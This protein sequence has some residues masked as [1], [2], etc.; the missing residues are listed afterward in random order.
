MH[1]PMFLYNAK[2]GNQSMVYKLSIIALRSKVFDGSF[3]ISPAPSLLQKQYPPARP[4][5]PYNKLR[6]F[7]VHTISH[8]SQW[9]LH[10]TSHAKMSQIISCN[11]R[12]E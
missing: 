5:R 9:L 3:P 8:I 4:H 11:R 1:A 7:D 10:V 6:K 2:E 12:N